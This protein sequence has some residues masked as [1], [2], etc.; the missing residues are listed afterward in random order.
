LSLDVL[1]ETS[2]GPQ[3][4]IGGFN[5]DLDN[6]LH[7]NVHVMVGGPKNM[8]FIPDAAQDPIFW[9]HHCNIDRLWAS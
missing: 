5:Q 2:Y 3:G 4:A 8:G 6:G 7:G 9:M 1:S